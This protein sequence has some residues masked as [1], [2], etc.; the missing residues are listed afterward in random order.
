MIIQERAR[1]Q[2]LLSRPGRRRLGV[3]KAGWRKTQDRLR[4]SLNAQDWYA[5]P[6][7]FRHVTHA[8]CDAR[9]SA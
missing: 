1:A 7:T 6:S 8:V 3:A 5:R 2:T 4:D 9:R